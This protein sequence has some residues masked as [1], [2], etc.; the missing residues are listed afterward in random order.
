MIGYALSAC[1][2]YGTADFLAG[3]AARRQ[4]VAAALLISQPIAFVV[5]GIAALLTPGYPNWPDIA[6]GFLAGTVGCAG[7]A[8]LYGSLAQGA[9][10]MASSLI[11][12][13][14][15]TVPVVAGLLFGNRLTLLQIAGMLLALLAIY[16]LKRSP[17]FDLGQQSR[18][19]LLMPILA[20]CALGTYH[21]L[22]SQTS[23]AS[24]LWPLAAARTSLLAGVMVFVIVRR[25]ERLTNRWASVSA[26]STL[27]EVGATTLALLAVRGDQLAIAGI[28]I[29]LNPAVTTAFARW[30]LHEHLER[31][32]IVGLMM[33]LMAI[34]LIVAQR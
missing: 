2:G 29:A 30:F 8:L 24:G 11:G 15:A 21:V 18:A 14:S 13:M 12:I 31:D 20:G 6:L 4:S 25:P 28:L 3:L 22:I 23:A 5:I 32:H 9:M 10:A 26:L 1:L 19:A 7:V 16:V 34:G 33:S 27:V 17:Q